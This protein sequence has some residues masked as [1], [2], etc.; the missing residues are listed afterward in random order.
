MAPFIGIIAAP[1]YAEIYEKAIRMGFYLDVD[2]KTFYP[3]AKTGSTKAAASIVAAICSWDKTGPA[4]VII[5]EDSFQKGCAVSA[6]EEYLSKGLGSTRIILSAGKNRKAADEDLKRLES[7]GIFA[8]IGQWEERPASHLKD[9]L[10]KAIRERASAGSAQRNRESGEKNATAGIDA[11]NAVSDIISACI[12]D[13]NYDACVIKWKHGGRC[14]SEWCPRATVLA[15]HETAIPAPDLPEEPAFSPD[16]PEERIAAAKETP[17]TTAWKASKENI[18]AVADG[19]GSKP[20]AEEAW[21]YVDADVESTPKEAF[22]VD[23]IA[24]KVSGK[25][26]GDLLSIIAQAQIQ[27]QAQG[28]VGQNTGKPKPR[29]RLRKKH[30]RLEGFLS[31][32]RN[33]A[34]A[35]VFSALASFLITM[36]L[37]PGM[38]SYQVLELFKE[39]ISGFMQF[40]SI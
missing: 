35:L 8:V 6:I 3:Q 40:L 32:V 10:K 33:V 11:E 14:A 31:S 30:W 17:E 5:E 18:L 27:A 36:I 1:G 12:G 38:D 9:I 13:G 15:A 24:D 16:E 23:E 21:D 20:D 4:A 34:V 26:M 19:R 22:D 39:R 25:I 2:A 29:K 28:K 37:N 7:A